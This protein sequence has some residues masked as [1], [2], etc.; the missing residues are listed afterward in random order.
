MLASMDLVAPAV[1]S[2]AIASQ[3]VTFSLPPHVRHECESRI[4]GY[5]HS[6]GS[7]SPLPDQLEPLCSGDD[8]RLPVKCSLGFMRCSGKHPRDCTRH[9]EEPVTAAHPE[10]LISQ[11]PW[12]PNLAFRVPYFPSRWRLQCPSIRAQRSHQRSLRL[13]LSLEYL[14]LRRQKIQTVLGSR[15]LATAF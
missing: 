12:R 5:G 1:A 13:D 4:D 14:L 6:D 7:I 8:F 2:T 11:Q 15:I 3:P 9:L 10:T